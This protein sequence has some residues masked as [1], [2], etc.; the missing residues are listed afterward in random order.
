MGWH[1]GMGGMGWDG[2]E[3]V[4]CS[5][6]FCLVSS[7]VGVCWLAGWFGGFRRVLLGR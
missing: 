5:F 3:A 2:R 4:E 6:L 1:G 7:H